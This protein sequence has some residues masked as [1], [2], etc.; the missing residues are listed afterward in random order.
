MLL[1]MFT[2]SATIAATINSGKHSS[3]SV[4][5]IGW[6]VFIYAKCGAYLRHPFNIFRISPDNS[7]ALESR[8]L[9]KKVY[10]RHTGNV[11]Q[12]KQPRRAVYQS[13]RNS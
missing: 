3:E 11:F 12:K 4:K 8:V 2:L 9:L 6:C 10:L 5:F 7:L 1:N 13:T